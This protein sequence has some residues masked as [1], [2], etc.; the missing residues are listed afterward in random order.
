MEKVRALPKRGYTKS[1]SKAS[2]EIRIQEAELV[3]F[4]QKRE[5]FLRHVAYFYRFYMKYAIVPFF[6]L[7]LCVMALQQ[8]ETFS[9]MVVL[10]PCLAAAL[11]PC[12]WVLGD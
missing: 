2:E 12:L 4:A 6:S 11:R 1:T 9:V 7:T 5:L 3:W 10:N 8:P